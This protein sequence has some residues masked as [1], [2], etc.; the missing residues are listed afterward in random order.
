MSSNEGDDAIGNSVR[1]QL[2]STPRPPSTA[3][4]SAWSSG[5]FGAPPPMH[6][7]SRGNSGSGPCLR[8]AAMYAWKKGSALPRN[9]APCAAMTSG[10]CSASNTGI[11]TMRTPVSSD[12]MTTAAPPMCVIGNAIGYTSSGVKP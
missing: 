9:V 6:D 4:T 12:E 7:R 5:E 10:L 2:E 8:C 3:C 1:P 11:V